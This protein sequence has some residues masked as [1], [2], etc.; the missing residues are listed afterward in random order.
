MSKQREYTVYKH[1]RQ[2]AP[3]LRRHRQFWYGH[4]A[5]LTQVR[6]WEN[7][8]II[9][10]CYTNINWT[11]FVWGTPCR[12]SSEE[13]S[14]AAGDLESEEQLTVVSTTKLP[15]TTYRPPGMQDKREPQ[16]QEQHRTEQKWRNE[17]MERVWERKERKYGKMRPCRR[18]AQRWIEEGKRTQIK[19]VKI[20]AWGKDGLSVKSTCCS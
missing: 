13:N 20:R 7:I 15:E 9:Y 1:T 19:T 10:R 8:W 14:R 4:K 18:E 3:L 11:T 6:Q 5:E 17:E 12:Q 2:T 16:P